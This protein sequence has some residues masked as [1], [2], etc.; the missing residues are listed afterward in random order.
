MGPLDYPRTHPLG[1]FPFQSPLGSAM[2]PPGSLLERSGSLRH[3]IQRENLKKGHFWSLQL[4]SG[5][6]L[7]AARA[8]F[9]FSARISLWYPF[10]I[11]LGPQ[12]G[13]QRFMMATLGGPFAQFGPLLGKTERQ[14]QR[15]LRQIWTQ[16]APDLPEV[17]RKPDFGNIWC[18]DMGIFC[19]ISLKKEP[20]LAR[21]TEA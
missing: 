4:G 9:S 13:S 2:H 12:N 8:R 7:A 15:V 5:R 19:L 16:L 1:T 14:I 17:V 20:I 18:S 6:A 10:W 3:D 21:Q 11:N